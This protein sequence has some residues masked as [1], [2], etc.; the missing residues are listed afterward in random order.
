MVNNDDNCD[1]YYLGGVKIPADT[2]NIEYNF[3]LEM[4]SNE[5]SK[6]VLEISR[7]V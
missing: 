4:P 5:F 2:L 7:R 1:I 3:E 6:G